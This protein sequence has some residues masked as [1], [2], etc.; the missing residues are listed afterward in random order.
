MI[1]GNAPWESRM[2]N[3]RVLMIALAALWLPACT[4]LREPLQVTL[5]G[6]EPRPAEG[7]ELRMLLRLRLQNPNDQAIDYTGTAVTL[8][9]AGKTFAT[10]VSDAGGTVPRFGEALIAVPVTVSALSMARQVLGALDG[11]PIDSIRYVLRGRLARSGAPDVRF[12]SEG[13]L[14]L[15]QRS[16]KLDGG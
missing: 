6:L 8:E 10:G 15:P 9:V 14:D 12:G 7:L 11:Q 2:T 4:M 3:R 5:S 1:A 16:S 13:E